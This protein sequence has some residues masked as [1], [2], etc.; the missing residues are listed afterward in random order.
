MQ[1]YLSKA[2]RAIPTTRGRMAKTEKKTAP[3][4]AVIVGLVE[5]TSLTYGI[6]C[7]VAA[8]EWQPS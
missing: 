6:G 4:G 5:V 3:L 2:G 8:D 7:H 1:C